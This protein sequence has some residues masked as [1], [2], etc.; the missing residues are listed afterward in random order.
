MELRGRK[1]TVMGLGRFGGGLGAALFA[2]DQGA[3]VTVTDLKTADQLAESV[4][5]LQGRPVTFRLGEHRE[6]DF[7]TADVVVVS[8]AVKKDDPLLAVARQAGAVLTSEMNLFLERCPAPVVAVTGSAGKSTTASLLALALAARHQTHFGGNIGRSLL[9]ELPQIAPGH[10]VLLELSSFQLD[11]AA[12]LSWSPHLAVVTNVAPNHLDHHGSMEAYISAK[13]NILRWQTSRDAA[14]LNA[15][16][17]QTASWARLTRGRACFFS[18]IRRLGEGAWLEGSRCVISLDGR[19]EEAALADALSLPGP[20]NAAN[21]LAAA[22]A[23]RLDGVPLADAARATREFRGLPHRLALVA[24][25]GGV[26]YYNDSKATTPAS[27]RV[28]LEAFDRPVMAIAGGYDKKID[29]APLAD[30]LAAR[31]RRVMLIG[32]TAGQIKELL[33]QRGYAAAEMAGTLEAAMEKIA[34]VAEPGDV[35]LLSP[36]HA[37][38]GQFNNYE[39]R[40]DR[41]TELAR[42]QRVKGKD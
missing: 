20:H 12:E 30:A 26:R 13:Q 29:L 32:Q 19:R 18:V 16:D 7:R 23:A 3:R 14:V 40:G 42:G 24:E 38:Y 9:A 17:A 34:L 22:L 41:F 10:R 4:A 11:S 27:T 36:G 37:S 15:D 8:P 25:V 33:D 5:A 28:A 21:F 2:L 31:A 39:Q 35:V 1:V 6:E